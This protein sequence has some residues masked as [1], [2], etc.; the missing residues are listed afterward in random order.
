MATL[1]KELAKFLIRNADS[2]AK[3]A[4]K[5][6]ARGKVR[7]MAKRARASQGE[8]YKHLAK[9]Q[10]RWKKGINEKYLTKPHITTKAGKPRI[11]ARHAKAAVKRS[12][13]YSSS[14]APRKK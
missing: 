11:K 7:H 5:A 9:A 1:S 6:A 13:D 2:G 12:R 3:G 8:A 10:N 4:T 14:R